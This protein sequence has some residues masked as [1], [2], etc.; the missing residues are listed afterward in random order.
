MNIDTNSIVFV[1]T[2]FNVIASIKGQEY[3]LQHKTLNS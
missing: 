3:P 2:A 1:K